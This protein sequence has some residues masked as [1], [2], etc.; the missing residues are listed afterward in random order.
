MVVAP[1]LFLT[2]SHHSL[3]SYDEGYYADQARWIWETGDWLTPQW[4][5]SAVYD[6]AI[7][8][9]WFIALAYHIFGLNEFSTR[10]P[11]LI[12]CTASVLLTYEIGLI[13]FDRHIA[14]LGGAI[15]MLMQLWV[16]ETHIAHQN[17]ILV[18]VEMLGIWGLLKITDPQFKTIPSKSDSMNWGW[19]ILAGASIGWGFMLKGLMIFVW[20]VTLFPYIFSG[21]RYKKVLL[22]P[23]V[24]LGI[25]IGAIPGV[26][27]LTLSCYKYGGI[28]PVQEL[29]YKVLFLS[30]TDTYN[31]SPIYYFWN[32]PAN[33]FPWALFSTIGVI[34]VWRKLSPNINYS[35]VTLTLGYPISLFILLSLFKTRMPYYMM[36]LLPFMALL[37]G[38]AFERFTH[39]SRRESIGW[40]R[41]STWLSYAFGGLGILLAILG[42]LSIVDPKLWG[43]VMIPQIQIYSLPA[44]ILGCGWATIPILWGRWESPS[45]PYW[46]GSWLLPAWFT[47]VAF[48]LQGAWTDKSPDFKPAFYSLLSDVKIAKEP[49]N[50]IIETVQ[51]KNDKHRDLSGE[52]LKSMILLTFYTP[53]LGEQINSF[54]KL[55][56]RAYAWTLS[57]APELKSQ[58]R[59]VGKIQD[60]QLIQKIGN[61]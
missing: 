33:I 39:I 41:L 12:G 45:I 53:R 34:I 3:L 40:Y 13:L 2:G 25:L 56:D 44:I 31:P 19:G 24:Y 38:T 18:A 30:K 26:T 14:W 46:L 27:W 37:A 23:S 43:I 47:I 55:P 17:I 49:I 28:M 6:R 4:W 54:D 58:T 57:V 1:V 5:G 10:L 50:L 61:S 51:T 35:A 22:N 32:L 8:L 60:W 42:I 21:Q 36:Q 29:I 20:I 16:N 15:L 59:I 48:G 7:G 11:N 52:E 9:Q